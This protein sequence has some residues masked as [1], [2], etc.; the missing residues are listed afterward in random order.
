MITF[1]SA[2]TEVGDARFLWR[3]QR[4]GHATVPW[5][6]GSWPDS[7]SLRLLGSRS[8]VR[9]SWGSHAHPLVSCFVSLALLVSRV[10][11][12]YLRARH[13]SWCFELLGRLRVLAPTLGLLVSQFLDPHTHALVRYF[14]SLVLL[15]SLVVISLVVISLVVLCLQK[16]DMQH[17]KRGQRRATCMHCRTTRRE[18]AGRHAARVRATASRA[19]ASRATACRQAANRP[20]PSYVARV[21]CEYHERD[22]QASAG[23]QR[24]YRACCTRV[25]ACA[26]RSLVSATRHARRGR[27]K[28]QC[29]LT[30][31]DRSLA[32]LTRM[33]PSCKTM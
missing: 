14:C 10:S 29:A 7:W 31:F 5:H 30:F 4:G 13:V 28:S 18:R 3:E 25:C 19:T 33:H 22:S 2:S 24:A 11:L 1:S 27:G 9:N 23:T 32:S 12:V 6:Y 21:Q 26:K 16:V 17:I 8:L 15:V 20:N